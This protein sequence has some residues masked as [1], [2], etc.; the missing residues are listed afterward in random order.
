[1]EDKK[2]SKKGLIIGIIT[3]VVVAGGTVAA[4]FILN[5]SGSAE[6]VA[7]DAITKTIKETAHNMTGKLEVTTPIASADSTSSAKIILELSG[8]NNGMNSSSNAT[9]TV[10]TSAASDFVFRFDGVLQSDGT[11]Y[12]KPSDM[13][14]FVN[15]LI[16]SY[17]QYLSTEPLATIASEVSALATK[18]SANWW[19]IS[20]PE[21]LKS[22]G[23]DSEQITEQFNCSIAATN[24]MVSEAG[25]TTIAN[26]YKDNQFLKVKKSDQKIS[27]FTSDAYEATVDASKLAKFWNEYVTSDKVKKLNDCAGDGYTL[28]AVTPDEVSKVSDK[29]FFLDIDKDRNLKGLYFSDSKEGYNV[30]ADFRIEQGSNDLAIAAPSG[31]KPITDLTAD[32]VKL[33]QSVTSLFTWTN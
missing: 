14:A 18:V 19:R 32:I 15:S 12:V 11:L 10:K 7:L 26:I 9:I 20:V 2:K 21:I 30:E 29:P 22:F 6:S 28:S 5:R 4:F 16:S 25:L 33:I 27:S 8:K 1:M 23:A 24:E 3:A 17:S 31:A 13:T